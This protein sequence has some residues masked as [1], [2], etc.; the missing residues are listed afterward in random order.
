MTQSKKKH[1]RKSIIAI[2][3]AVAFVISGIN[4]FA[5]KSVQAAGE[6]IIVNNADD[7][8]KQ[9][10]VKIE[11][12]DTIKAGAW[13]GSS[14]AVNLNQY[15]VSVVN[16]S[17][18]Y[19]CDWEVTI[20]CNQIT[21]W[22]NGWNNATRS[23]NQIVIGTVQDS[24][25]KGETWSNATIKPGETAGGAGF[26]VDANAL[27]NATVKLTYKQGQST[28]GAAVDNTATDPA[29]IGKTDSKVTAEIKM[30]EINNDYHAYFLKIN[31][32]LSESLGD[33]I[34]S[35][36]APGVTAQQWDTSWAKY[37]ENYTS[38]KLYITPVDTTPISA[39]GSYGSL[40]DGAYKINYSGNIDLTTAII[41]V[42]FK[43]G[44]S[45]T[46]AFN[47]V[48]SAATAGSGGSSGGGGGGATAPDFTGSTTY[49]VPSSYVDTMDDSDKPTTIHGA[50][51]V[52][53][54]PQSPT[55]L[56][57][58]DQNNNKFQLRGISSHGI[59]WH[60]NADE[61]EYEYI[62]YQSIK[63]CR[64]IL[65]A[66]AMRF[67]MY[68]NEYNGYVGGNTDD[69]KYRMDKGVKCAT[70]LGMYAIVDWHFVAQNPKSFVTDA[71]EFFAYASE[72]YAD[73]DNVLYE[74]CN[75]PAGGIWGDIK[76]YAE[77]I[78]PII[79]AN[80][81]DAIIIVGTPTW[82]QDVNEAADN[83]VKDSLKDNVMYTFHFYANTHSINA[84]Y[85]DKV[86]YAINKI[87]LFVTEYGMCDSSGDGTNN[88][89]EAKKW[90]DYFD[91]NDISYFVW[92]LCEKKET[93]S[94]IKYNT[95]KPETWTASDLSESGN[96]IKE[97]YAA[98]KD[99][100]NTVQ[101]AT[102]V[103]KIKVS[104]TSLAFDAQDFG[105]A[106]VTGKK[107]TISNAGNAEATNVKA[108]LSGSDKFT[109]S[110]C[111]T[112]IEAGGNVELTLTPKTGLAVGKYTDTLTI[113][114]D[115][116]NAKTVAISFEVNAIAPKLTVDKSSFEF[117]TM[118]YGYIEGLVQAYTRHITVTNTGTDVAR[119]V[120]ATW[121]IGGIFKSVTCPDI[122]KG[123]SQELDIAPV[124]GL[125]V[126]TYQDTLTIQ[127]GDSK[128]SVTVSLK[129]TPQEAVINVENKECFY[130][131]EI[132]AL[133]YSYGSDV[134][135]LKLQAHCLASSN[136][137]VGE[138][139]ITVTYTPNSNYN[140]TVNEAKLTIKPRPI[141]I[142][143]KNATVTY[144]SKPVFNDSSYEITKGS[145]VYSDNLNVYCETSATAT[146]NVGSYD[147]T[148]NTQG[149]NKNYDITAVKGT[150]NVT[151]LKVAAVNFPTSGKVA[152]VGSDLSDITLAGGDTQYGTFAWKAGKAVKG[153]NSAEVVLTLNTKYA[154][155]NYDFSGV[156]GYDAAT[157]T[158]TRQV[159]YIAIAEDVAIDF[160]T[161]S[162]IEIGQRVGDSVLTGDTSEYGTFAWKDTTIVPE[163]I[164]SV[165]YPVVFTP[166]AKGT[167]KG[168]EAF[169]HSISFS[170]TKHQNIAAPESAPEKGKRSANSISVKTEPGMEYSINGVDYN[171]QG[172]FT[173]LT[174]ATRYE[175]S[176]RK[177]ETNTDEASA[178][179]AEKLVV[180]TL[181]EDPF[182]IDVSKLGDAG[183]VSGLVVAD[184]DGKETEI[185]TFEENQLTL[186]SDGAYTITGTNK[187]VTVKANS[188]R[189]TI[190][191]QNATIK[192]LLID[193][194]NQANITA[195]GNNEVVESIISTGDATNTFIIA[196]DGTIKGN[197]ID[198]EGSVSFTGGVS[199]DVQ[200]I[201]AN[202]NITINTTGTTN[203][204]N[205]TATEKIE[206]IDGSIKAET[207]IAGTDIKLATNDTVEAQTIKSSGDAYISKGT[208]TSTKGIQADNTL[209]IDGTDTL[210]TA[211]GDATAA[212]NATTI[213]IQS[214]TVIAQGTN[215]NSAIFG[216]DRV[217]MS[218]GNITVGV[219]S[220]AAAIGTSE[221]G[222]IVVEPDKV[223]ITSSAKNTFSKDPVDFQGN[224]VTPK[225]ENTGDP[226]P[227]DNPEGP[228]QLPGIKVQ[229]I[230]LIGNVKG[231]GNVAI[232]GT[233]K[234]ARKKTMVVRAL[235]APVNATNRSVICRS[236]DTSVATITRYGQITALK[237]GKTII[238][239]AST[240]GV[241]CSF[242]LQ[243]VKN[244]VKKI[245]VKGKKTLKRKKS[246]K[247]KLKF[248]PSKSIS[249]NVVFRSSN[250]KVATVNEKGVVM[251][252]K[253]GK[254]TINVY[255]T[256]GSGKRGK[257]KIKVK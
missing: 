25:E 36:D 189:I 79:R 125:S 249:K 255:A 40:N 141:T 144:G 28:S 233:F 74:I 174:P 134:S 246:N 60:G 215:G 152:T 84:Q 48:V 172:V 217:E 119:D 94:L 53:M 5:C 118:S 173:G 113:T 164:G 133:T 8:S 251:A 1:R 129:I 198:T 43:T 77:T 191:L 210:I 29:V 216:N 149:A 244:P 85:G 98:R 12:T 14:P 70:A 234:L 180:Y 54:D 225:V 176:V 10:Y 58:L 194:V 39:Y 116:N 9:I 121:G 237:T 214:G 67:A 231:A 142:K 222:V 120:T 250:T 22:N 156:A 6:T 256:D 69:L 82:S 63:N 17:A 185:A 24:N 11:V 18:D 201:K 92:S 130:G 71:K 150:L 235:L 157:K 224:P 211:T 204:K 109:V 158:I 105:Y 151:A 123:G 202:K 138:Y 218:A 91:D 252:L 160:P 179:C 155:D 228:G 227:E 101:A 32:G 50:L 197:K 124:Q 147:I 13:G 66:N 209:T 2:M 73:Y 238:S 93:A 184:S 171:S 122:A 132:P 87:P 139:A 128:V 37:Y 241:A 219:D 195:I 175:I 61:L 165:S 186:I 240:D 65:N 245:T 16:N 169:E 78:I 243:V 254:V 33:W 3:M 167:E 137:G 181:H 126:G 154:S 199:V 23:G 46:G 207:I 86:K 88:R 38:D 221:Q 56:R 110:T 76:T 100:N 183:Y 140:V 115:D 68:A 236:S 41:T 81:P 27:E 127:G 168:I 248:S 187:N 229:S 163:S 49:E 226:D 75:E 30:D 102:P 64:D 177:A 170:V 148:V 103:S 232:N 193:D 253:K 117:K 52:D 106:A 192:S 203:S 21:Q 97:E 80:D 196:G 111:P 212:L 145:V 162:N 99:V 107:I 213:K 45:N 47:G 153:S 114:A 57:L 136:S 166:N 146:S 159:A 104:A 31:N 112:S 161:A 135:G 44:S 178:P 206:V 223:S 20:S 188:D 182:T 15:A 51:H 95:H 108:V 205:I 242:T 257:I 19:I 55:Y 35:I 208:V 90:W 239:V 72:R 7:S 26:Q 42:Y 62:N 59:N 96:I 83:P 34:V 89:G 230:Q 143:A 247:L 200:E 190:N 220:E 131:E 4:P